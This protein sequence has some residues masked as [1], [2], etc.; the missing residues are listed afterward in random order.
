MNNNA[1]NRLIYDRIDCFVERYEYV[2][3]RFPKL[4]KTYYNKLSD[5]L[6]FYRSQ[7]TD[8]SEELNALIKKYPYKQPG[9]LIKVFNKFSKKRV[10]N[11]SKK[12]KSDIIRVS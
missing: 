7:L 6:L 1:K 11:G 5:S 3:S 10:Q 9:I 2:S 8:V 12:T 4:R